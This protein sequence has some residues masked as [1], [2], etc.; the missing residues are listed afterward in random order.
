MTSK[1]NLFNRQSWGWVDCGMA[2]EGGHNLHYDEIFNKSRTK[3]FWFQDRRYSD[4]MDLF[5]K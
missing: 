1:L 3:T 5:S 4:Q 2:E